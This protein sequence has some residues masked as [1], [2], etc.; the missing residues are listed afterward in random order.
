MPPFFP[1]FRP[2]CVQNLLRNNDVVT[3]RSTRDEANLT[4][5]NNSTQNRSDSSHHNLCDSFVHHITETNGSKLINPLRGINFRNKSNQSIINLN[6][7][8]ISVEA[9]FYKVTNILPHN[10]LKFVIENGLETIRSRGFI[11]L[12]VLD[13]TPNLSITHR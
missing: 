7:G 1:F 8:T 3:S 11:R 5:A 2:K 10:V 9:A 4:R 12:Y 6:R 13:T